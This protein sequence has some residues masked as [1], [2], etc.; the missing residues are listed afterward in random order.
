MRASTVSVSGDRPDDRGEPRTPI[1]FVRYS[2]TAMTTKTMNRTRNTELFDRRLIGR[3]E[4]SVGAVV[5]QAMDRFNVSE[6]A[7]S[8]SA[9]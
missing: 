6:R 2:M 7:Q 4:A 9:A 3:D 1:W 8:I 5:L